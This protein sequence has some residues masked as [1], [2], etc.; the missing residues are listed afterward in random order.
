MSDLTWIEAIKQV[1]DANRQSMHYT[2][3]LDKIIE[4][5]LR[6]EVGATPANTVYSSIYQDIRTKKKK[7]EFIK[8]DTGTFILRKYID[9]SSSVDAESKDSNIEDESAG[10][11]KAFGMFWRRDKVHWESNPKIFGRQS[12][13]S[14]PVDFGDE[15]GVYVLYDENRPIYVGR[16]IDQGIG[17]RIFQHTFDRLSGRWNRF[18][19][20]GL[21]SVSET[22]K[23]DQ[24]R[25]TSLDAEVLIVTME[26][27]LIETL[28]PGLNRKRGDDFKA[29]EYLQSEDPKIQNKHIASLLA[30]IQGKLNG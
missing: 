26:A 2:E 21:K 6:E 20:F 27:I 30:E 7:S 12:F 9:S 11:I 5:G 10:I 15:I 1:L 23:L 17:K 25:K 19:W 18:S 29:V 16:A 8:T 28:E 3:I 22:G 4:R 14:T 13:G 24:F